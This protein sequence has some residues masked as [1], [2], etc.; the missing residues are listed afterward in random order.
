MMTKMRGR[1]NCRALISDSAMTRKMCATTIKPNTVPA[2]MRKASSNPRR[3]AAHCG[4]TPRYDPPALAQFQMS[5]GFF[6]IA[7]ANSSSAFARSL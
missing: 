2:T 7:C 6:F 3:R 4:R 5:R 1:S